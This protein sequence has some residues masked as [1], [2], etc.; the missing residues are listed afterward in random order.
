MKFKKALGNISPF[1]DS[2]VRKKRVI[3]RVLDL[4]QKNYDTINIHRLDINNVGDYYCAPHLYFDQLKDKALDISDFRLKNPKVV[5]NWISKVSNNS[6]II[7]GGGLLNLRHFDLQMKLFENLNSKGK[8]TVIWG[9]GHNAIDFKAFN[10]NKIYNVDV[11]K[12][13]LV[14]TR[15]Y[16]MPNDWVPCVSCLHPIFNQKFNETQEVGILFGKKSTKNKQ[17]LNKLDSYPNASNTTNLEKMVNFIGKTNTLITDSY[18]A[19]YWGI[20]LEKKVIAIPTT[21]KF[22][23]FKYQPIISSFETFETDLN[24]P[25]SYSGVLEECR[26]V[27]LKFADKVFDYLNL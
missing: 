1:F 3:K 4:T 25:Q 7:G 18:H 21:S 11:T 5:N 8:K 13:G 16:S 23:D 27:N 14:G 20:L 9:P 10:K 6:L 12:F 22:F 19:M 15:D 26:E 2:T 17:L 24:K